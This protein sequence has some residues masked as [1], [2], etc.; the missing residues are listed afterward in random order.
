MLEQFINQEVEILLSR[1]G[2]YGGSKIYYGIIIEVDDKYLKVKITKPIRHQNIMMINK[3]YI[4][5]VKR[6]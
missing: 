3:E 1:Q 4:I 2:Y 6:I 5:Y